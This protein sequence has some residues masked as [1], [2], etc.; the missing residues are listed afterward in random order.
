M[1]CYFWSDTLNAFLF[2][3]GPMDPTLVDVITLTDLD[4]TTLINPFDLHIDSTHDIPTSHTYKLNGWGGYIERHRE[5]LGL[6]SD[7]EH[8]S[9]LMMWLECFFFSGP[10]LGPCSNMQGFV[11]F[12]V[13]GHQLPFRAIPVG[14]HLLHVASRCSSTIIWHPYG[15]HR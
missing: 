3:I 13:W 5:T 6:V 11:E 2:G 4:V 10:A 8:T 12:L 1:A 9:F 7:R 14:W 15:P